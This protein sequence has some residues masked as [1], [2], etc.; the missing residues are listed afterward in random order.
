VLF[1]VG[2]F[3]SGKGEFLMKN[4]LKKFLDT[5]TKGV[6][7]SVPGTMTALV[8]GYVVYLAV[9]MIMTALKGETSMSLWLTVLLASIMGI[10][11]LLACALGA[12]VFYVGWQREKK[13][14]AKSDDQNKQD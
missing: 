6:T 1:S 10:V 9:Q 11:G 7:N 12:Y 4:K 13:N 5:Q 8:G 3:L 14:K 2:L